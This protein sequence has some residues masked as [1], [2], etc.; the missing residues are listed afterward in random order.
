MNKLIISASRRT[1]IPAFYSEWFLNRIKAG[2]LYVRNPMNIH[3]ISEI[4]L[5][6]DV[7][8]FIVFWTKNPEE[9]LS[10]LDE[11]KDY[12]YYFQFTLTSYDKDIEVNVPSKGKCLISTFKKLSDKI[13]PE[14]VIWRYDPILLNE[15]Y[16]INYHT[17]NFEK[18]AKQLSGYTEKCTISFLDFYK[19]TE[20]N[21]KESNIEKFT[22]EDTKL[23]AKNISEIGSLYKLKIDTCS[24]DIDLE[25]YGITHAHCIDAD[26]ME[27][28]TNYSFEVVKDKNQRQECG[29]VE[30]I[31]IGSYNTC[32][33]CCKY[34]YANFNQRQVEINSSCHNPQSPLIYGDIN[35]LEDKIIERK[36]KSIITKKTCTQEQ[37]NFNL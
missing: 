27:K 37:L 30:S 29:C 26:L 23:I 35:A 36:V 32:K 5:T 16:T 13:G 31:D 10:K 8:D 2:F 21:L 15:K 34:C 4:K 1:D 3:Q 14:K 22:T 24:E 6:P 7:V 25:E 17:E 20:R 28:L 11:L 9:M 19:K 33:N 18:I 12:K